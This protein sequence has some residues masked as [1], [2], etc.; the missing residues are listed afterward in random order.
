MMNPK[1]MTGIIFDMDGTLTDS[2]DA[3]YESWKSTMDTHDIEYGPADFIRD[4]VFTTN[5]SVRETS[6]K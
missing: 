2:H 4:L 5:S 3:H 1:H 6:V